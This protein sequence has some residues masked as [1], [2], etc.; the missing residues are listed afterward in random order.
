MD[1][2]LGMGCGVNLTEGYVRR[3]DGQADLTE[4]QVKQIRE[5]LERQGETP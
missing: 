5:I 2:E 3:G 4:E 1:T